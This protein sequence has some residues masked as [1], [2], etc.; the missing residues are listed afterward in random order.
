MI[1]RPPRST[2]VRS[3]AASDVYKRQTFDVVLSPSHPQ[4]LQALIDAQRDPASPLYEQY[5][6]PGQF[7][8]RFGPSSQQVG[9]VTSWLRRAGLSDVTANGFA[10]EV[11]ASSGSAARALG[12]SME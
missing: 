6:A 12:I 10:V 4:E 9:A 3:S 7:L 8:Q 11:R 1:R 5:L 2:R